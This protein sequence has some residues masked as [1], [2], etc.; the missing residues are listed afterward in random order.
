TNTLGP[1]ITGVITPNVINQPIF[2]TRRVLTAVSSFD[3]QTVVLG[4]LIREEVR[5]VEDKTADGGASNLQKLIKER[6]Q[7]KQRLLEV[8]ALIK[9]AKERP[10]SPN[11]KRCS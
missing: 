10:E 5:K 7:L 2:S 8:E 3:G 9:N 11:N 6:D 4:G 1:T